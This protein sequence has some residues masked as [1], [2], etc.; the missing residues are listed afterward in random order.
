MNND[1]LKTLY[2]QK[3]IKQR[4]RA[5]GHRL[6][7]EY[8]G[9]NPLVIGVL[10]GAVIFLTDVIRN[11]GIYMQ[12]DFI[13]VSS[14][15]GGTQS[16]GHVTLKKDIDSDVRGRNVLFIEDII[17]TGHTLYFLKNLLA[18]RGAKSIRICTLLDKPARRSVN[19]K[20]DYV[21]F[22]IPNEFIVGYGMDYQGK[23]RNLPYIGI[24]KPQIYSNHN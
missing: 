14:Y 1:I 12:L 5:L 9:K 13:D 20:P 22:R 3:E 7:K 21:G 8:R 18:K 17:D 24:L 16:T 11:M 4:C 15:D 6:A 10:K 19:I 23:Y 2:D